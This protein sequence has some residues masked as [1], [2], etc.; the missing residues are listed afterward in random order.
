MARLV[1]VEDRLEIA[2]PLV[3]LL[4]GEGHEVV[5]CL[6]GLD[7]LLEA[8]RCGCD[9]VLLDLQLDDLHGGGVLRAFRDVS[10]LPVVVM[11]AAGGHWQRETFGAGATAC[12]RK[13]FDAG[14]LLALI[15]GLVGRS[16]E[17]ASRDVRALDPRDL[18]RLGKLS[19]AELDGLP[20]GAMRL[21]PKGRIVAY[22]GY[23]A[24]AVGCDRGAV[25]GRPFA[26]IAPCVLVQD[27]VRM[28]EDGY[29][30]GKL[31]EQLSYVFPRFGARAV[32]TVRLY[33]D[34]ETR[35]L[36]LFVSYR[37]E[38]FGREALAG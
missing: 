8:V 27:F 4:E 25:V 22:N 34:P 29:A 38:G 18:A 20:L 21:D 32:V 2:E 19:D 36:W 17:V 10:D 9:L 1:V 6:H 11:S 5:H 33:L 30:R 12:V 24:R 31:D 28:V 23:E 26:E 3:E 7:G 14:Q 13:P 15:E 16:P 37:G 35:G